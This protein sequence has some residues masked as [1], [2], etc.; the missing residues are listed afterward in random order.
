MT[1]ATVT[2]LGFRHVTCFQV[3]RETFLSFINEKNHEM[4]YSFLYVHLCF[5]F[6]HKICWMKSSNF[7]HMDHLHT[8]LHMI[9]FTHYS[10]KSL[11]LSF[12]LSFLSLSVSLFLCLLLFSLCSCSCLL[13]LL[14]FRLTLHLFFFSIVYMLFTHYSSKTLSL[15]FLSISLFFLSLLVFTFILPSYPQANTSSVFV[16]DVFSRGVPFLPYV[17]TCCYLSLYHF[18]L[19]LK[20]NIMCWT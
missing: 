5:N 12:C 19:F 3:S 11:S 16:Q 18:Y 10:F 6:L 9:F 7:S 14:T 13:H 15:F 2:H 17:L 4:M 1:Q 8:G 20:E